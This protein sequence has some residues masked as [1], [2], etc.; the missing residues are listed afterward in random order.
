MVHCRIGCRGRLRAFNLVVAAQRQHMP[1]WPWRFQEWGDFHRL[2]IDVVGFRP[3]PATTGPCP[4]DHLLEVIGASTMC[5]QP[6]RSLLSLGHGVNSCL[7]R[8]GRISRAG[9]QERRVDETDHSRH[10][11]KRRGSCAIQ[12]AGVLW[13]GSMALLA[14]RLS[15]FAALEWQR[16]PPPKHTPATKH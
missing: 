7:V 15:H 6:H 9:C 16:A 14:R 12:G 4:R 1:S 10:W 2:R 8:R 11:T 5:W 3:K 13:A